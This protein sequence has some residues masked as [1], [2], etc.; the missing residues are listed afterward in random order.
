MQCP[1]CASSLA[2]AAYEG[3]PIHTCEACGGE[4]IGGEELTRIL[5]SPR[6]NASP[7]LDATMAG[8]RPRF[9]GAAAQ[10]PRALRCPACDGAMAVV[11]YSGDS[12]IFVDRC[13]ICG[14]L[15]LDHEE[16]EKVQFVMEKWAHEAQAQLRAIA[17]ELE[18]A[19][20][21]A[22][23]TAGSSF[24][25]SRFAFVNAIVNKLLDAA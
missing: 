19:R 23:D 22:A 25:G 1:Q 6:R 13:G 10:P 3:V 16:L 14:G 2:P 18:L 4:F 5:R 8:H 15:W 20:R 21:K 9:G 12:G 17:G 11:N 24:S 7:K